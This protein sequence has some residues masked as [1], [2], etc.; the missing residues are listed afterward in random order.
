MGAD[1]TEGLPVLVEP[2]DSRQPPPDERRFA[3]RAYVNRAH[4]RGLPS[5][6]RVAT[7]GRPV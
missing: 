2:A 4:C 5:A 7:R 1:Y 3:R 6:S